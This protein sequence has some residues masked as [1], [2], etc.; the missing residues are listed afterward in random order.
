MNVRVISLLL[1]SDL[2]HTEQ[3]PPFYCALVAT[4]MKVHRNFKISVMLNNILKFGGKCN[5]MH[6]VRIT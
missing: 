4:V 1:V 6:D 3:K 2:V 5:K